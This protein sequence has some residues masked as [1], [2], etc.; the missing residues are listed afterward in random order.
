MLKRDSQTSRKEIYWEKTYQPAFYRKYQL[1]E[2]KGV[3][4]S[5]DHNSGS[6]LT[7]GMQ[8]DH[9]SD[10]KEDFYKMNKLYEYEETLTCNK[11]EVM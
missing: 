9:L 3:G 11:I 1:T 10:L 8:S 6:L 7:I 4:T 5:R 2:T